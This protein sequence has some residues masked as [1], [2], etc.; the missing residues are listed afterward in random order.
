MKIYHYDYD[1]KYLM[2]MEE[3]S[4]DYNLPNAATKIVPPNFEEW[5]EEQVP[6][7]DELNQQWF[8]E[9]VENFWHVKVK[10]LNFYSGRD[11]NGAV[12]LLGGRNEL[13]YQNKIIDFVEN[14]PNTCMPR[15]GRVPDV[16][17]L[18][19]RIDYIESC[20]EQI[21]KFYFEIKDHQSVGIM[22]TG[23]NHYHFI[24]ESLIASVRR[25]IDD[26][27]VAAFMNFFKQYKP[28]EKNIVIEGYSDIFRLDLFK[29]KFKKSFSEMSNNDIST[30]LDSFR[31][32]VLGENYRYLWLI[33]SI[34]NTYK[35][36]I[37]AGLGKS[38]YGINF[39]TLTVLGVLKPDCN[40]NIVTYHN[41][42]FRQIILGL[43]D[44]LDDFIL[45]YSNQELKKCSKNDNK[46]TN[47]L[48]EGHIWYLNAPYGYI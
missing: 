6:V 25:F 38:I 20:I 46:C 32:L 27:V 3:V 17:S 2:H 35:H 41:H 4:Y 44:Y 39:P 28:W 43:K 47:H 7:F 40:L 31:K 8:Y 21:E 23:S 42:N 29:D 45:R 26:L 12:Y 13:R 30:Q 33:Q 19:Q 34:S 15:I 16:I 48:I 11:S 22:G 18:W 36:S 14:L 5:P 24:I 10:E 37:T 9:T 1:D